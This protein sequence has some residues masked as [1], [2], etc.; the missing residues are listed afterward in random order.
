MLV[1]ETIGMWVKET[2]GMVATGLL[3]ATPH[4]DKG[5]DRTALRIAAHVLF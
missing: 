3:E 1:R 4:P 2:I 5:G